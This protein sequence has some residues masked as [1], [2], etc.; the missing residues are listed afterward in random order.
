[1]D[2]QNSEGM[3]AVG[4]IPMQQHDT[5]GR[6]CASLSVGLETLSFGPKSDPLAH[7][8]V[9]SRKLPLIGTIA[10][11]GRG[12]IWLQQVSVADMRCQVEALVRQLRKRHRGVVVSSDLSGRTDPIAGGG[13][14]PVYTPVTLARLSLDGTVDARMARQHGK[15]RN[16]LKRAIGETLR[17]DH[18]PMPPDAD[19]WLLQQEMQQSKLRGYRALPP[20]FTY[21]WRQANGPKATRLFTARHKG[22]IVAAM[23]F[24]RHGTGAS[25]HIGWS[26]AAGRALNAHNLLLWDA[27]CWLADR[28]AKWIDLGPLDTETS[29][30]LARFKLGSG[31]AALQLGATYLDAF[32]TSPFARLQRFRGFRSRQSHPKP[33]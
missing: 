19:H 22:N 11:I 20:A 12:P 17:V 1:M 28:G 6:T 31:A 10:Q 33:G 25:Y 30:G 9:I 4:A 32:A 2:W 24:L 21:V 26:N 16:R 8:Q 18:S 3:P 13:L 29:P 5:Y 23:L 7:V 27:S 15:W 14:L